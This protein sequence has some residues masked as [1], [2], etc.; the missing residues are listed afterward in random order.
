MGEYNF[1]VKAGVSTPFTTDITNTNFDLSLFPAF[2][3]RKDKTSLIN[4]E[5]HVY[6]VDL[7]VN[8]PITQPGLDLHITEWILQE[9]IETPNSPPADIKL[10]FENEK[11]VVF[12][13]AKFNENEDNKI[14]Y[15]HRGAKYIS[16]FP[17]INGLLTPEAK[18]ALD[19]M[20]IDPSNIQIPKQLIDIV[21]DIG[22]KYYQRLK[23]EY[24]KLSKKPIVTSKISFDFK[25]GMSVSKTRTKETLPL[26]SKETPDWY[27]IEINSTP[28][29]IPKHVF[30]QHSYKNQLL[31]YLTP[32]KET[33]IRT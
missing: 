24:L 23:Q 20:G 28:D 27:A 17:K 12:S 9:A 33:F 26:H 14:V 7:T 5:G 6:Y 1:F 16:I 19:A 22:P 21:E 31:E 13:Y 30:I 29:N 11:G 25:Y 2:I 8:N 10:I 15:K 32:I 18:I 4:K 3:K